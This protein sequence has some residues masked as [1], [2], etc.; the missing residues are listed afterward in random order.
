MKIKIPHT[1]IQQITEHL[2]PGDYAIISVAVCGDSSKRSTVMRN[3]ASGSGEQDVV[4][5]IV[6]YFKKK[7][8]SLK[9]LDAKAQ[10]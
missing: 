1:T 8:T 3:I 10:L 6:N 9:K 4:E 5:A 7:A 2:M